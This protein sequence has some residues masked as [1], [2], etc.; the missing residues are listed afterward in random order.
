MDRTLVEAR[1]AELQADADRLAAL[2]A[3]ACEAA[4]ASHLHHQ[5]ALARIEEVT[6]M[7]DQWCA[8]EAP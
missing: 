8:V 1:L 2:Y 7:R 3:R 5:M 6:R 4:Q